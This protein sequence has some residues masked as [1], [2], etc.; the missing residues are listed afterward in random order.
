M[1]RKRCKMVSENYLELA[2]ERVLKKKLFTCYLAEN[3]QV[4]FCFE[5]LPATT[6]G[7]V[8]EVQSTKSDFDDT[9][10]AKMFDKCGLMGNMII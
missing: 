4:P 2:S 7:S 5:I 10:F 3:V 6:K 9:H 8:E 1:T